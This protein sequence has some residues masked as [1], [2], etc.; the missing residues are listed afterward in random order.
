MYTMIQRGKGDLC[1]HPLTRR[2][3]YP[4]PLQP[5]PATRQPAN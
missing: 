1:T 3:E 5:K 2:K 4:C